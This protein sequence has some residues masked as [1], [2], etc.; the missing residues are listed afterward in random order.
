MNFEEAYEHLQ[1]SFLDVLEL[2]DDITYEVQSPDEPTPMIMFYVHQ[3]GRKAFLFSIYGDDNQQVELAT[4]DRSFTFS[5]QDEGFID[6]RGDAVLFDYDDAKS[7]I[8]AARNDLAIT[9]S[10][11]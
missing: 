3:F 4:A 9:L 7:F 1:N 6:A 11:S 2:Y 10:N 5:L 8:R